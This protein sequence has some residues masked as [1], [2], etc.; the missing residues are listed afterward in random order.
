[1]TISAHVVFSFYHVFRKPCI[2][3]VRFYNNEINAKKKHCL[4]KRFEKQC[5]QLFPICSAIICYFVSVTNFNSTCICIC[6]F[7][8]LQIT[9]TLFNV[10]NTSAKQHPHPTNCFAMTHYAK[11]I[12][13]F[14]VTQH[15]TTIHY[16]IHCPGIVCVGNMILL[17]C[18]AIHGACGVY[19]CL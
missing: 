18:Y 6:I 8:L 10:T 1:M 7:A 4:H 9:L 19:A 5:S 15:H 12:S 16:T 2:A 14:S 13:V 17:P 3:F 11:W